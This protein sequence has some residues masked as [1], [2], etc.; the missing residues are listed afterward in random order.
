VRKKN[1]INARNIAYYNLLNV[2]VKMD[3][4]IIVR[5]INVVKFTMRMI[6]VRIT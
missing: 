2:L 1:A 4:P 6:D 5:R 3:T